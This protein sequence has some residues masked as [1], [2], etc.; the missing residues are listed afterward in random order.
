[1]SDNIWEAID[2]QLLPTD[3]EEDERENFFKYICDNQSQVLLV[4]DGLDEAP[5]NLM[6]LFTSLVLSR[7]LSKCHIILTSREEGSVEISK[8]CDALFRIGFA[9]ENSCNYITHYFKDL[10]AEGQKLLNDIEENIELEELTVNP[11]LTAILCLVYE[12][13]EGSLPSSKTQLYLEIT[14]C[15]LKRFCQKQGLSHNNV[16]LTGVFKEELEQLGRSALEALKRDEMHIREGEF[17]VSDA[18]KVNVT[19]KS[20]SLAE[21]ALGDSGVQLISEGLRINTTLTDLYLSKNSIGVKG[22]ESITDTIRAHVSLTSLELSHNSIGDHGVKKV[23]DALKVNVSLKELYLSSNAIGTSGGQ[24]LAE[25]LKSN[26]TLAILDLHNNVI[27][28][29]GAQSLCEAL[30]T[31]T[32]LT[33]LDFL[34]TISI[35][36]VLKHLMSFIS[37]ITP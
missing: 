4:L 33:E 21:N 20:L 28:D 13:L 15:I 35:L 24:S 36:L 10:E 17:T 29:D 14:E 22:V 18:L 12:D 31:N 19:I 37:T 23:S 25:A 8:F 34:T 26:C 11:F 16:N 30:K 2:D 6:K 1:M 27:D 7:E 9:S 32:T 5:P 3:F